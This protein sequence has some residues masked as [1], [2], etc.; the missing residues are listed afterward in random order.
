MVKA[1]Y[2]KYLYYLCSRKFRLK[3]PQKRGIITCFL[4]TFHPV[5]QYI[6]AQIFIRSFLG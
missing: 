6:K 5:F 4:M 3:E 2:I 1:N